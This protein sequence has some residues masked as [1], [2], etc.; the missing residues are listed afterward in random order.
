[1]KAEVLLPDALWGEI[2]AILPPPKQRRTRYPGRRPMDPQRALLGLLFVLRSG[3]PWEMLPQE[4]GCGSGTSCWRY[5][6]A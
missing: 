3:I 4:L 6:N 1:M 5:L 2:R